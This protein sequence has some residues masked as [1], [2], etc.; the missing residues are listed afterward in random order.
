MT[1]RASVPR[2][3][4]RAA[5]SIHN[6]PREDPGYRI[7]RPDE[8]TRRL[9]Q[10]ILVQQ[11]TYIGAPHVWNGDEVGMWGADDPDERKPMVWADL[12]YEDEMVHPFGRPRHRDRVA[13]DTALFR[14]YR[15]LI[16]LR[17]QHL[18]LLVDGTLNWLVTDDER[19]LLVYDRVLGDQRA[20]VAFNVSDAAQRDLGSRRMAG[21]VLA[22]PAG[23]GGDRRRG[24]APGSAT[25]A[26][27]R[28]YGSGS[29][30]VTATAHH[31]STEDTEAARKGGSEQDSLD[32]V[33]EKG[34][35]EV[36]QKAGGNPC[37]RM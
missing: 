3:T 30:E 5:T 8:R 2:S 19:G 21:I 17:K 20:I 31:G 25:A 28:G 4:T 15:D 22:F 16:A 12:R 33:G 27:R 29:N 1:R 11:F 35:V 9:Q 7:D 14:V 36:H 26:G 23:G 32:A 6:T 10:L 37:K 34:N 18:R 24:E 13:P